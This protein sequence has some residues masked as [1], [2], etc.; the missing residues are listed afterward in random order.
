MTKFKLKSKFKPCGDQP[1][2]IESLVQAFKAKEKFQTLLGVTGSGKTFTMANVIQKMGKK[3]LVL[4]PNKT[5]AAQLYGEFREFFPEN[6]VEFFVSYY[7][8]YQPE[9]Y[10]PGSDT[11][12]EKDASINDK[13]DKLRHSATR[14]LLSR[15]DVIVIASVSCIYGIGDPAEY[16][17][18]KITIFTGDTLDRDKLLKDLVNVQY[19]RNDFDFS[20]GKFR[21]RGD[22]VEVF[23]ASEDSNVIRIEFFGDEVE[24]LSWVDP[25]RG[26]VLEQVGKIT[27]F[28]KS[29]Y[30]VGD[31][32]LKKAITTIKEELRSTLTDLEKQGKLVEKQRLEGRTLLDLE[33]LE[34]M[35]FCS[36]I[37][38]YSRH[39]TGLPPGAPPPTLLDYFRKN[40]L[41]IIDESHITIPQVGGMYNGDR[42]RKENLVN[43]GFRL[44]SALDNRP[45]KFDEFIEKTDQVLFVSATP[46][47]FE[48][49]QTKGEFVEQIIRPTGLL[50]PIIE[51]RNAKNQVDEMLVEAKKIIK[52]GERV[53]ITTLTKKLAEELTKYFKS[54]GLK[55]RYLHSDVATIERMEIIQDLRKGVFD[56]LVGINLLREGLDIPEVSLVGILDADKE[57][58]LRSERSL[59][60]TIGRAARN[61]RGRVILFAYKETGSMKKA[62]LETNRRRKI[63]EQ[64]NIDNNITPAT[65]SKAIQGGVLETLRGVKE[66]GRKF[67]KKE[68]EF[69]GE[70]SP[71]KIQERIILLK[72]MMKK[73]SRDLAFEEAAAYRDEIKELSD[74]LLLL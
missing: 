25:L 17:S 19:E 11:Y 21:V 32:K 2:A 49:E 27:I 18:Q 51:V 62:I 28:P 20:R 63:Q 65:I 55:I 60:Q 70:I 73:A 54:L 6:A 48:L 50:D 14:S 66:E 30:V 22:V 29:H 59:I 74:A 40:F 1:Q 5:L 24:G 23:P 68:L 37:E 3:T 31:E 36:G 4:A 67:R 61:S 15:E 9:A 72:D 53:L 64:S 45:L 16:E 56:I 26:N 13:I 38:N 52:Q 33:M 35:G 39:L 8:Y 10:V 34:E 69:K 57:G 46:A 42:S 7:D 43:Y 41:L 12:I 71:E 47:A 44:P 58:F